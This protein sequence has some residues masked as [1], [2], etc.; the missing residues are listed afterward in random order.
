MPSRHRLSI[1][2]RFGPESRALIVDSH[3]TTRLILASQMRALGVGQVIQ[4]ARAR[5]AVQAL[6]AHRCEVML[7][8]Q[9]LGDG[10]LGQDLIDDL[11]RR[12][13]LSLRTV[14]MV[15]SA[16]SSYDVVAEVAESAVDGFIIKPYSPGGLE[17]RLLR[18]FVRKDALAPVYDA[19]E[20]GRH[21]DALHLCEAHFTARAPHWSYAARLGAEL[22]LRLDKVQLAS[23][24]F[25]EVLAVKTVPWAKLGIARA[26][27]ASGAPGPAVSTI[28][29]LLSTEP[30]YVDAYDVL[31]RIHAEQGNLEAALTA[32][33]HAAEITPA[34]VSRAQ[35]YGI[36][37]YYAGD[38]KQA[39]KALERAAKI[40][41]QS[42]QFDPQILLLLA[43]AR[44]RSRDAEGLRNCQGMIDS[45]AASA[46][47]DAPPE[48]GMRQRLARFMRIVQALDL[49][50]KGD[51]GAALVHAAAL[52]DGLEDPDFDVEAAANL[53]SLLAELHAAGVPL[54]DETDWLRRT[55]LRFCTGRQATEMLVKACGAHPAH[56][57]ALRQAHHEIGEMAQQ[58]LGEGLAGHHA[59]AVAQLLEWSETTRNLKLLHT[60]RATLARYRD[61]V[62]EHDALLQRCEALRAHC[63]SA[64]RS[65]LFE[66]GAEN[67]DER[68]AGGLMLAPPAGRATV[69]SP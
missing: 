50:L 13:L 10:S 18:A 5:E 47:G 25:S 11:R 1:A 36:V 28:E 17:D 9:R 6:D 49:T 8:E 44:Y 41:L 26:L 12:G 37:A 15:I 45:A 61:H 39:L 51:G 64:G 21:A 30:N 59:R 34:S 58:A 43:L 57:A 46:L 31:G 32:Y 42:Q 63:G 4:C 68:P 55:G 53:L 33:R 19:I 40:G 16:D 27:N 65:P 35:K 56:A 66:P 7:C 48:V 14:V 67:P 3:S 20:A 69:A 24:L 38:P 60:A 2:P 52:A 29:G 23:K 54:P 62:P 22:A